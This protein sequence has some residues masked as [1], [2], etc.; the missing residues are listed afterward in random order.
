MPKVT[1]LQ[2]ALTR[3]R[4][5]VRRMASLYLPIAVLSPESAEPTL[6]PALDVTRADTGGRTAVNVGTFF[7]NHVKTCETKV[8]DARLGEGGAKQP[9]THAP[10]GEGVECPPGRST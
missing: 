9:T 6:P 8:S 10:R 1:G 3:S 7:L 5:L 2:D 4:L